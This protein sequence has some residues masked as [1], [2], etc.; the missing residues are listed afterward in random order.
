MKRV[1]RSVRMMDEAQRLRVDLARRFADRRNIVVTGC[2]G[3]EGAS[4]VALALAGA[5][6]VVDGMRVL[7]V[8]ANPEGRGLTALAGATRAKGLRNV[9][10]ETVELPVI[11]RDWGTG[12]ALLPSGQGK[13]LAEF[14]AEGGAERVAARAA[15]TY[16]LTIWDTGPVCRIADTKVLLS[17]LP[18]TIV[19]TQ[20]DRTRLSDFAMA[21]REIATV[22][23][24]II[25]VVRNRAGRLPFSRLLGRA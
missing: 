20:S 19:V 16:D 6:K 7:V 23:A 2:I 24:H 21:V 13:S 18:D 1:S 4:T 8:D 22:D 17:R 9:A 3:G 11:D 14:V 5:A 10:P 25:A 15:K 12:V